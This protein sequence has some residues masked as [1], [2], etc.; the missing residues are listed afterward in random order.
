VWAFGCVLF[1]MLTGKRAFEGEDVTDTIAAVMRGEPDW[2][3]LP[4]DTPA[5]IRLLLK[6]CLDKDRR[7]RVSDISVARFLMNERLAQPAPISTT[8]TSKRSLIGAAALGALAAALVLVVVA[9]Q[10]RPQPV[11]QRSARFEIV[12]PSARPTTTQVADHDLTISPDGA[13]IA[14]RGLGA[15]ARQAQLYL[16]SFDNLE[17]QPLASTIG[18]RSPFFSPDGQWVGFFAGPEL[19]KVS[20][21]GGAAITVCRFDGNPR[22]GSWGDDD[23]IVFAT[24]NA[25]LRVNAG[26]GEAERLIEAVVKANEGAR[27]PLMLP[28]SQAF[29]FTSGIGTSTQIEAF[30]LKTRQR[31]VVIRGGGDAAYAHSGH[32]LFAVIPES[33]SGGLERVAAS[34]RAV[35]FDTTRLE[36]TSDQVP[37]ADNVLAGAGGA[38]QFAISETG[39]LVFFS[40]DTPYL[41]PR[42]RRSLVWVNR[43]GR[44]EPLRAPE[45]EYATARISPDG[46]HV[47]LDVRDEA[48]DVSIWDLK[49]A[50]LTPLNSDPAQ[51]MSPFWTPDGK[52]IVWTSTRGGTTPNMYRQ[53]ADGTGA[54]ER[55]VP[56]ANSQ[57]PTSISPDGSQVIFFGGVGQG[58]MMD[59]FSVSLTASDRK[60]RPLV[61]SKEMDVDGELSPDGRWLAYHSNESG[62]SQVFVRPYPNVDTGRSQIST[63]GGTRAAWSRNGRELFYLDQDGMLTSVPIQTKG[64][65]LSAGTPTRLLKTRYYAGQTI[66]GLDLRAYDVSP[67]GNRFLMIKEIGEPDQQ[68]T[69]QPGRVVVVLNWFTELKERL[70]AK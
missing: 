53:S 1:E 25:V 45:R 64:D 49:R 26:G 32:L 17:T 18:A 65:S 44:E 5:Q 48:I 43:Q 20:V 28:G 36:V 54:I 34:L 57:F 47:V 55:L 38:A 67:D 3:S 58:G 6:R 60:P 11:D 21:T 62:A 66:L 29:V 10:L 39:T 42:R 15:G 27:L 2:N 37:V 35:R 7:T 51:D 40:A 63:T 68:P 14:F 41:S 56:S 8:P 33:G 30:H 70:S 50:T 69:V 12:L 23:T 9:W 4:A 59:L 13:R 22:G 61:Q 24:Q 31:K 52:R 46:A 19:R 16:R